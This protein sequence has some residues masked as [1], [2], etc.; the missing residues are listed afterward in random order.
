[1][2]WFT[3]PREHV[4]ALVLGGILVFFRDDVL[5]LVVA[6]VVH[7]LT[8]DFVVPQ[9]ALEDIG[10]VEGWRRLWPMIQASKAATPCTSG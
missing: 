6:A 8:K 2:G 10:A 4:L 7:V 3:A 5:F 9:M 1:M